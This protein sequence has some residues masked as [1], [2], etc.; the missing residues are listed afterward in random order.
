MMSTLSPS[1]WVAGEAYGMGKWLIIRRLV[2]PAT[3]G[4]GIP[5]LNNEMVLLLHATLA[6]QH[7]NPAG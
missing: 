1:G 6:R 3:L 5:A 7:R 4:R 2:L